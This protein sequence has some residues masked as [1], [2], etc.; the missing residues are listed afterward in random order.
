MALLPDEQYV[1]ISDSIE[2]KKIARSSHNR[3]THCGKGGRVKFPSDY[4]SKKELKAMN[5]D[6][7][8]Y[9]LNKPMTWIEFRS[10]P[11]DLQIMYIKKLRNEFG[12]PDIVLGKAMGI[13][14]SSFSRAMS[15]LNLSLGRCAAAKSKQWLDSEKSFKF[16]EYW[17]KF[18]KEE[19]AVIEETETKEIKVDDNNVADWTARQILADLAGATVNDTTNSITSKIIFGNNK[20][21]Q[22]EFR[23]KAEPIEEE[24]TVEEDKVENEDEVIKET[25]ISEETSND[26]FDISEINYNDYAGADELFRYG[27]KYNSGRYPSATVDHIVEP[28][29]IAIP[30]GGRLSF[31]CKF[32]DA[33]KVLESILS[34]TNVRLNVDWIVVKGD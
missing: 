32:D 5:G 1:M 15:E 30:T 9:N 14:K 24:E 21:P 23:Y 20:K 4:L 25:D 8:S 34:G 2:K 7:K 18:N 29:H 27:T 28:G 10:M 3:K 17:N 19:A 26:D 22:G 12:V 33:V 13:C 11:K 16:F 31:D 6:V